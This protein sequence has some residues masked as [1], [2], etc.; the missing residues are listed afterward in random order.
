MPSVAQVTSAIRWM[1]KMMFGNPPMSRLSI[2]PPA[3]P[4]MNRTSKRIAVR[5]KR[6][7]N[8]PTAQKIAKAR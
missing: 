5:V 8:A 1:I 7:T 3:N 6:G 4:T 2:R